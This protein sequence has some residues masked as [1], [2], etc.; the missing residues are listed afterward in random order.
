M[1]AWLN[2]HEARP[3]VFVLPLFDCFH[4]DCSV[5]RLF[6]ARQARLVLKLFVSNGT[7][8]SRGE[9]VYTNTALTFLTAAP[10]LSLRYKHTAC[11]CLCPISRQTEGTSKQPHTPLSLISVLVRLY[12]AVQRVSLLSWLPCAWS[13]RPP[14]LSTRTHTGQPRSAAATRFVL[15]G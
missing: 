1:A 8:T 15:Q 5:G 10:A 2:D 11:L 12:C 6:P 14:G 9:P 13:D 7:H 4:R 3:S